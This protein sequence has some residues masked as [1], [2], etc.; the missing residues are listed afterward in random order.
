MPLNF[1]VVEDVHLSNAPI[2]EVICQVRFPRILR[3]AH[4]E[5]VAFQERIR[6]RFPLL[7][8]ERRVVIET[9]GVKPGGKA[10]F[11]PSIFRFRNPERT[12]MLSL[13]PD[14]FAL[15]FTDYEHWEGFAD[16]LLDAAD[17]VQEVYAVPYSTRIGLRYIN[18]VDCS[19]A[20]FPSFEEVLGLFRGELTAMLRTDVILS[21]RLSM[22]RIETMSDG[23]AFTF[24]YG[25]TREGTPPEPRFV[26]DF[27]HYAEGEL[28][29]DDLL[30]RCER[31][32]RHIYNA[33]RWCIA[34]GKLGVF[35][36]E[37]DTGKG[38]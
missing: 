24:R 9:E 6:K 8:A 11:P 34:D 5:P 16:W 30:D 32:H 35:R 23:D 38:G 7:E 27:D 19:F 17:A 21:P 15:S 29:L 26:L 36:P 31:Y 3:I 33:F 13:A 37:L 25:L 12:R 4:E 22:H 28:G 1:P 14:F 20:G 2:R 18:M 10:E